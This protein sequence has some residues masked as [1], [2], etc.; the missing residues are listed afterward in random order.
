MKIAR[1]LLVAACTAVAAIALA[2]PAAAQ[3]TVT[4]EGVVRSEGAPL[5]SVQVTAVNAETQE[6]ARATTRTNGEFRILGLFPGQYTV[7]V[8]AVGFRPATE[9]V[10]IIIGQRARLEF[11]LDKG[12]A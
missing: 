2:R 9:K 3:N 5:A 8:R 7:S 4:L 1:S 11:S 10:Q 6:T 12:V